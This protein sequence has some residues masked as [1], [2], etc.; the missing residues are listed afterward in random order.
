MRAKRCVGCLVILAI[1]SYVMKRLRSRRKRKGIKNKTCTEIRTMFTCLQDWNCVQERKK[2]GKRYLFR[3]MK[4]K[5]WVHIYVFYVNTHIEVGLNSFWDFFL[6]IPSSES[7]GV[8]IFYISFLRRY[9]GESVSP[10][11]RLS[12]QP[13]AWYYYKPFIIMFALHEAHCIA[14]LEK[15]FFHSRP[16]GLTQYL[17]RSIFTWYYWAPSRL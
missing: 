11:I 3:I 6:L 9:I 2:G 15:F 5:R 17:N 4:Q 1:K 14:S 16:V 7:R 13:S 10:K 8:R 12:V